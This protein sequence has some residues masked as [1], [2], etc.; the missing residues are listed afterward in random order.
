MGEILKNKNPKQQYAFVCG[1]VSHP[2]INPA[3]VNRHGDGDVLDIFVDGRID[4]G[5]YDCGR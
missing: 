4:T 5:V 3:R 1:V 2:Q